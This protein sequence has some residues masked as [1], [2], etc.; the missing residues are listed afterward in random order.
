MVYV[1]F[2]G[3]NG[4]FLSQTAVLFTDFEVKSTDFAVKSKDLGVFFGTDL[5]KRGEF[6]LPGT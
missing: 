6:K 2:C 3:E 1:S 4:A 5:M